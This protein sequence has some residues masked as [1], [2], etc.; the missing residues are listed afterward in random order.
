MTH[1][2]AALPIILLHPQASP[3]TRLHPLGDQPMCPLMVR[4]QNMAGAARD[5][6]AERECDGVAVAGIIYTDLVLLRVIIGGD[7]GFDLSQSECHTEDKQQL[8]R[9]DRWEPPAGAANSE[10]GYP[11]HLVSWSLLGWHR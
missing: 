10:R 5:G 8:S 4:V 11:R 6:R 9:T 1:H 3:V 2:D 7:G